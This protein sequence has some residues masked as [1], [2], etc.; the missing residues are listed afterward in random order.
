[1]ITDLLKAGTDAAVAY[2]HLHE[3]IAETFFDNPQGKDVSALKAD[4]RADRF[5][6]G[7]A[8]YD[9][10]LHNNLRLDTTASDLFNEAEPIIVASREQMIALAREVAASHKWK[11]PADGPRCRACRVRAAQSRCAPQR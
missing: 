5:A 11:T 4:Y 10:A 7:R 9:W 6:F 3:F 1:M 2:H 8:E